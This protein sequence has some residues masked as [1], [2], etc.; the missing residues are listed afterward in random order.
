MNRIQIPIFELDNVRVAYN[1]RTVLKIGKFQF[2]RGTIYGIVGPVGS[3][4]TTLLKVLTGRIVPTD[5]EILYENEPFEKNWLGRIKPLPEV[6]FLESDVSTHK[7]TVS[8]FISSRLP[9]NYEEVRRRY[10]SNSRHSSEW[11]LSM[12]ALSSGLRYRANLIAAIESDPKVL[13]IDD[14]AKNFDLK[15]KREFNRR[16]RQNAKSRG[17]TVIISTTDMSPIRDLATVI[18][19]LDN[20]HISK[21]RSQKNQ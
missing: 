11:D 17:T 16:I 15:L 14:Y 7:G 18:I 2:H 8:E 5:G 12:D 21:V 9:K 3:G 1:G 13:I 10:Y 20:G 6:V 19:F 4:K